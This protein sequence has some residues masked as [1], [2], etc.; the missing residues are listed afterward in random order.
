MIANPNKEERQDTK[1]SIWETLAFDLQGSNQTFDTYERSDHLCVCTRE[2]VLQPPEDSLGEIARALLYM[3]LRYGTLTAAHARRAVRRK[4][5]EQF[6]D[7]T[8][9]DCPAIGTDNSYGG[10][11]AHD[12]NNMGY[13]SCLVQWHR[14]KPPSQL[15]I[16]RNVR[17]C[18]K[19]QGNRV[20][21]L[22]VGIDTWVQPTPST[23]N[24]PKH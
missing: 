8:L 12:T 23:T 19:Y 11:D 9:T 7:L 14:V 20:Q 13:F 22:A 15:E 10:G 18:R 6:L 21:K 5:G 4:L 3:A 24:M 17:V 1:A 2:H 16:K